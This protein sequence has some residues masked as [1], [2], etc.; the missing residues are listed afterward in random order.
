MRPVEGLPGAAIVT[1]GGSAVAEL[2]GGLADIEA[3]EACTPATRFQLCSVSKQFTAAAVLLL[4][5]SGRLGLDE[6]VSRW[7]PGGPPQ[8]RQ[9]TLHHLLSHT[10]GIPHWLEAPGLDPAEPMPIG[11]RV[12]IIQATPLRTQPG[13]HWH[14][15]SLGFV[16]AAFIV[17][18]ASGLPYPQFLA[19]TILTPLRLTQT[20][21]G[22]VPGGAARGY[23]DG[24]PVPSWDLDTMCGTGDIWSTVGDLTRFTTALHGRQLVAASSLSAMCTAHAPIDDE[25]EG[26]LRL[27]T[28]GYGYGMFTGIFAGHAAWYHPGDNPGYQSLACWIPDRAASIVILVNDTA[29]NIRGLLRRLLPAALEPREPSAST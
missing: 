16:L 13:A 4:A 28:T 25:D 7:L 2:A 9:V 26:E 11:Q 14:Y 10:A 29:A 12:E 27:T 15:S 19:E 6:P 21:V 17:E 18:Q 20:T 8:W 1:R 5:E 24:Q 22:G 3:G 23:Q